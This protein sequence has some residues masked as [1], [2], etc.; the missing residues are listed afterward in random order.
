MQLSF[1]PTVDNLNASLLQTNAS[2]A[3]GNVGADGLI[4]V[5]GSGSFIAPSI[6]AQY[7]LFD[8]VDFTVRVP[9]PTTLGLFGISLLGLGI[10]MRRRRRQFA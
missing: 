4:D 7:D 5:N 6:G 9:E 2:F 10:L 1:I 3:T 8:N